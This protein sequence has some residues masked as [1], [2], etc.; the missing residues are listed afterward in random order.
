MTARRC[1]RRAPL[2]L[3]D[4]ALAKGITGIRRRLKAGTISITRRQLPLR[5]D[6]AP[7]VVRIYHVSLKAFIRY[8]IASN[9]GE[10]VSIFLTAALGMP[11]GFEPVSA[12]R[13]RDGRPPPTALGFNP[14]DVRHHDQEAAPRMRIAIPQW[15]ASA[16]GTW[17]S[18][19]TSA[20]RPSACSRCGTRGRVPGIDFGKDGHTSSL[21]ARALVRA[22]DVAGATEF[23]I[24][25][26]LR[27]RVSGKACASC[28]YFTEGT[29]S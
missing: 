3:A 27:R 14:P 7:R 12:R 4:I 18:A 23:E 21:G 26:G 29:L 9:V 19:C 11:N 17:W 2:K 28:D 15:S 20:P 13:P 8:M 24:V 22:R 25:N 16:C 10:V 6:V 5:R 1:Q